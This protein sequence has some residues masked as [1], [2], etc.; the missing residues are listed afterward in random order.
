MSPYN[1]WAS[2]SAGLAS[3]RHLHSPTATLGLATPFTPTFRSARSREDNTVS[4]RSSSTSF[5]GERS[6]SASRTI[7]RDTAGPNLI[8]ETLPPPSM[9]GLASEHR[10]FALP[11]V[12]KRSL[13][14]PAP[15]CWKSSVRSFVYVGCRSIGGR[16]RHARFIS[17]KKTY[18]IQCML[19]SV[20]HALIL[21]PFLAKEA[22][23]KYPLALLSSW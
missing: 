22:Y 13:R 14:G 2:E 19:L 12:D 1:E 9:V 6:H 16:A 17:M 18:T 15:S 21:D 23:S 11:V 10:S 7:T 5:T 20:F 3:W 8:Q 4:S